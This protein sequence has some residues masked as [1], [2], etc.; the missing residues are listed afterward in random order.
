MS[1]TQVR[2]SQVRS[3]QVRTMRVRPAGDPA[4]AR[5]AQGKGPVRLT[6]RGRVVLTLLLLGVVMAAFVALGGRS[7]ATGEAGEAPLT[8]TVVVSEGDTLWAIASEVGG[9]SDIRE[10]VHQIEELNSLPGPALVEG[11]ELAV[12]V[13]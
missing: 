8:R 4:T 2:S 7:V 5:P 6:R 12:P 10:V 1:S 9:D 3:T 11:Q 13:S